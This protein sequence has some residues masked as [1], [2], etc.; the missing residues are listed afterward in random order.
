MSN[1]EKTE[2]LLNAL[3]SKTRLQILELIRKGTSNP[4]AMARKL[5]RHRST[6]E[7]HLRVL[8]AARIVEKVPSL[9]KGGQL[10][11][12]YK[13]SEGAVELLSVVQEA[14]EKF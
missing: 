7:K 10:T 12:Q 3:A 2:K 13:I 9:S 1:Y 8:L 5:N 6:V 11:I 14:S 4:G